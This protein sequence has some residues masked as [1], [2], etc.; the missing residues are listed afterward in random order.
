VCGGGGLHDKFWR[1][2][3]CM[4]VTSLTCILD[5][6]A[7]IAICVCLTNRDAL[8][9]DEDG[10]KELGLCLRTKSNGDVGSAII[11]SFDSLKLMCASHIRINMG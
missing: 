4:T 6:Q 11:P 9:L 10:E 3:F 5:M 8:S 2:V 7:S 1:C